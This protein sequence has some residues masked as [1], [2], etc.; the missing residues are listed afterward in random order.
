M[1]D[2][3]RRKFGVSVK[4]RVRKKKDGQT[5]NRKRRRHRRTGIVV[6]N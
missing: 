5:G 6:R 4:R 2:K 3:K 1:K